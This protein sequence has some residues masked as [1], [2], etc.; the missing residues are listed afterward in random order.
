MLTSQKPS[1]NV[2]D[3]TNIL[4]TSAVSTVTQYTIKDAIAPIINKIQL[5]RE[6]VH[7]D[8]NKLHANYVEL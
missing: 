7:S 3:Q 1:D 8:Y 6:S 5:L 4:D 2:V